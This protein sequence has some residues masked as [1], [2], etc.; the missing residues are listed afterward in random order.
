MRLFRFLSNSLMFSRFLIL[1]VL[2]FFPSGT[3]VRPLLHFLIYAQG[4]PS[5]STPEVY[6]WF[7]FPT[8]IL[9]SFCNFFKPF[10][11]IWC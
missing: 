10:L 2:F 5:L 7:L 8:L 9:S 1:K 3:E 6:R 11:F 4:F